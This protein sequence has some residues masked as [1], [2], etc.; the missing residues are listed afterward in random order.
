[1]RS[2]T[3]VGIRWGKK[4]ISVIRWRVYIDVP[5]VLKRIVTVNLVLEAVLQCRWM[6]DEVDSRGIP[7][8]CSNIAQA[9]QLQRVLDKGD[10][11]YTMIS[12]QH[13]LSLHGNNITQNR[14]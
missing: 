8:C 11:P 10:T 2:C 5:R 12:R 14:C 1:M 4:S 3:C 7:N 9:A 13:W 6:S